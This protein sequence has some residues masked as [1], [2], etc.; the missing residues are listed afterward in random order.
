MAIPAQRIVSVL[1]VMAA[2]TTLALAGP[3]LAA[4]TIADLANLDVAT[5]Y[6]SADPTRPLKDGFQLS[7]KVVD[8]LLQAQKDAAAGQ[9]DAAL[10]DAHKAADA[11]RNSYDKLK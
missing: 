1:S 9:L 10:A 3:C 5:Q 8:K 7:L 2:I 4:G 11:A 6:N